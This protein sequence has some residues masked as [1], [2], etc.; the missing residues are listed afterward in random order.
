[1]RVGYLTTNYP[2]VS[3]TFIRREI[4]EL[5]RQEV[6]IGIFSV[7]RAG[8]D[9]ILSEVDAAARQETYTLLPPRPRD[10]IV[11]HGT[12]FAASPVGWMTTLVDSVRTSKPGVR[13]RLLGIAWF[14]QAIVLWHRCSLDRLEHLHVHFAD[15]PAAIARLAVGF[16][17]RAGSMFAKTWSMTVHGPVEFWDPLLGVKAR[18]ADFVVCISSFSKSQVMALLP[19]EAWPKLHVVHCGID[20]GVFKPERPPQTGPTVDLVTVGRLVPVKGQAVLIEAL[21]AAR[22]AEHDVRL[23][24]V[25]DGPSRGHLTSIA[26]RAGV[27]EHIT[28][29]GAQP[30]DAIPAFLAAAD[31]FC[32]SSFAEGVPVVLME[33]MACEMPVIATRIAGIPELVEDGV[34]GRLVAA[35]DPDELGEAICELADDPELRRRM[36]IAGRAKVLEEFDARIAAKHLGELISTYVR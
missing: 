34:S 36:G 8:D 11:A 1:M 3:H 7:R 18:A 23:T 30:H 10:L 31:V 35:G 17:R 6:H 29:A 20:A 16:S 4:E 14:A 28:W 33:A 15:S 13:G 25:G 2:K 32:M 5:R 24:V 9:Q 22:A 26:E 12:A 27:E 21:A 19:E